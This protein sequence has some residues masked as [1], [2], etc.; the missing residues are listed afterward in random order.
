MKT[1]ELVDEL[2]KIGCFKF[3]SYKLKNGMTTPFYIDLRLLISYPELLVK[4]SQALWEKISHIKFNRICGVPYNALPIATVLSIH[5]RIPMLLK[6]KEVKEYG[7]KKKF[8]GL[9]DENDE[10]LIIEDVIV[11]GRSVIETIEP[12]EQSGLKIA[13]VAVIVDREQGGRM[14]LEKDGLH[15]TSLLTVTEIFHHL[16]L[17]GKIS[18]QEIETVKRFIDTNQIVF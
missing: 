15:V 2:F 18:Q 3:G 10:V 5:H 4:I 11:S 13:H 14:I 9:F 7:T 1:F 8:E 12:L 6:R 17:K 16:R